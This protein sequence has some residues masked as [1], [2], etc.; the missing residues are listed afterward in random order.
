MQVFAKRVWGF[1]PDQWPVITFHLEGNR[2]DL[3]AKSQP[4]DL[5]LFVGTETDET[6]PA[7]QGRLLGLA[8]IGRN[9][10]VD[11]LE[12]VDPTS[13]R[14]EYYDDRKQ[15]R[16]PK[17]LAMLRAWKFKDRPFLVDVLGEQL[18]YEAT[19]RAVLL[20]E[21][22]TRAVLALEKAEVPV[23][24]YP[25]VARLR[26]LNKALQGVTTGPRPNSWMRSVSPRR[27]NVGEAR[28]A[29]IPSMSAAPIEPIVELVPIGQVKP[30]GD[31][32]PV[33]LPAEDK[34]FGW[35]A[36]KPRPQ[37]I[38]QHAAERFPLLVR[39]SPHLR[40]QR[41]IEENGGSLGTGRGAFRRNGRPMSK[42]GPDPRP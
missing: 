4:G 14:P 32:T 27:T 17:A 13:L 8:E 22:D 18:S 33:G 42:R 1:S 39:R 26:A 7:N 24:D 34:G 41:F 37:Q 31:A 29:S 36:A 3:V 15:L 38:P 30:R 9:F 21:R 40:H 23:R 16:W 25:A 10:P 20:D 12:A 6:E 2:D 28:S 19:V 5:V 11:T 35:R